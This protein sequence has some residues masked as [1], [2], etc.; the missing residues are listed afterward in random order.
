MTPAEEAEYRRL[1]TVE[2]LRDEL[3]AI[4][5]RPFRAMRF[6]QDLHN[7]VDWEGHGITYAELLALLRDD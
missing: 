5:F 4:A 3:A 7:A 6:V 2:T 1:R